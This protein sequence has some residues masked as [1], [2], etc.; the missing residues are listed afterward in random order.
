MGADVERIELGPGHLRV[1]SAPEAP[2]HAGRVS[3]SSEADPFQDAEVLEET[4]VSAV[5][6]T[7]TTSE[8]Q[9]A[10]LKDILQGVTARSVRFEPSC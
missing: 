2:V 6:A 8:A 4:W 3:Y 7:F 9:V 10:E 1:V 5:V